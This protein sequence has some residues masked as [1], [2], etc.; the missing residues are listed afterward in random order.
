LTVS[1]VARSLGIKPH[2]VY[3]RIHNGTIQI[4]IDPDTGLYL[5]PDRPR[6]ITLFQ[7]LRAGKVQKLRF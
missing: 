7:Q 6:T 4:V 5:F 3:D 2:W 1:Q